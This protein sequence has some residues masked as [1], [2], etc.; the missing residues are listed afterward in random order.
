MS[1]RAI[2]HGLGA[3]LRQ[4]AEPI[5]RMNSNREDLTAAR[6][7]QSSRCTSSVLVEQKFSTTALTQQSLLRFIPQRMPHAA[8][9][10][11]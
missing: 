3:V 11:G 6:V 8:C 5:S 7:R 1:W 4:Q 10:G 2:R 9:A